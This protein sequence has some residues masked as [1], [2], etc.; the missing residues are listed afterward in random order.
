MLIFLP[1]YFSVDDK[2][3][4]DWYIQLLLKRLCVIKNLHTVR[5]TGNNILFHNGSCYFQDLLGFILWRT[6][7]VCLYNNQIWFSFLTLYNDH[8]V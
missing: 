4:H 6:F 8:L 7:I 5:F 1:L 2:Y 3:G